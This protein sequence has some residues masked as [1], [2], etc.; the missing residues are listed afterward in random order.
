MQ[1]GPSVTSLTDV[2]NAA[3]MLASAA[4]VNVDSP[5]VA[6]ADVDAQVV[7]YADSPLQVS[8]TPMEVDSAPLLLCSGCETQRSADYF[9]HP[10]RSAPYA[11]CSLCRVCIYPWC[12]DFCFL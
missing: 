8:L 4:P 11:T 7:L 9:V 12:C 3:P 10:N 1:L 2:S 6:L 5:V